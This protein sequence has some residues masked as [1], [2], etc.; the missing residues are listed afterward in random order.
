MTIEDKLTLVKTMMGLS[1]TT[2]YDDELLA[3]LLSAKA[4]IIAW[5]Y[6]GKTPAN[7][8]DVP[9]QYEVTQVHAVLAGYNIRGAENQS[10][11]IENG[12]HRHFHYSDMVD[13]IHAHVNA[14]ARLG[15]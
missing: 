14:Y 6:S 8:T 2:S 13:Y 9:S 1:G 3:Y 5:L 4:E 11:S 12:V 7:V 15:V 10:V